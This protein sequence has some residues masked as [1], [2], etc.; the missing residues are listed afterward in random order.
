MSHVS[1][2][3]KD[4]NACFSKRLYV[5]VRGCVCFS[6]TYNQVSK[7]TRKVWKYQRYYVIMHHETKS[8]V[9][10]PFTVIS[11]LYFL[12]RCVLKRP[13]RK[14]RA[15]DKG[16]KLFLS[17][18]EEKYLNTFEVRCLSNYLRAE[19]TSREQAMEQ[20]VK[21]ID[22][23]LVCAQPQSLDIATFFR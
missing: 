7:M 2:M 9:P 22:E 6:N 23:R 20:R 5:S 14:L 4:E 11:Y 15:Y 17:A 1:T 12:T 21:L 8:V 13:S 18:D 10:P 3:V 19:Q 16:L